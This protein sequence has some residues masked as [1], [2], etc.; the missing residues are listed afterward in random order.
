MNTVDQL[1]ISTFYLFNQKQEPMDTSESVLSKSLSSQANANA[2]ASSKDPSPRKDNVDN[3]TSGMFA[4][5]FFYLFENLQN[6]SPKRMIFL[7][8]ICCL[9]RGFHSTMKIE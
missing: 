6:V 2:S 7:Q 4:R 9:S 8:Q 5:Y 1:L 3:I